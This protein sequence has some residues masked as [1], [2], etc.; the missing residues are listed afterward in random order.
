ML[1]FFDSLRTSPSR[2]WS[3]SRFRR[4]K[5]SLTG[6]LQTDYQVSMGAP[7]WGQNLLSDSAPQME[8]R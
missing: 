3:S 7:H 2:D 1:D 4:E 5:S 8:Q 6:A